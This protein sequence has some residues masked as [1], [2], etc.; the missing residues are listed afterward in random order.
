MDLFYKVPNCARLLNVFHVAL[1]LNLSVFGGGHSRGGVR[2]IAVV[3]GWVNVFVVLSTFVFIFSKMN[4]YDFYC[5]GNLRSQK[6]LEPAVMN[7][8]SVD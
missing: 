2:D 8:L 3:A 5:Q 6:S 1:L 4:K 7:G